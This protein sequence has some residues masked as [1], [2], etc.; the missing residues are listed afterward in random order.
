MNE[1]KSNHNKGSLNAKITAMK[2]GESMVVFGY[3]SSYTSLMRYIGSLQTKGYISKA[4]KYK[5]A[6]VVLEDELKIGVYITKYIDLEE[7]NEQV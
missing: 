6:H 3:G 4:I 2:P 1:R 7:S 5:K